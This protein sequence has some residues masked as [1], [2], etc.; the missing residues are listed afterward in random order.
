MQYL[1]L[2]IEANRLFAVSKRPL[3]KGSAFNLD[4]HT[5]VIVDD[6]FVL[7][8][9]LLDETGNPIVDDQGKIVIEEK[10]ASEIL[11]EIS[12][13]HQRISEYPSI[14]DQ[15]DLMYHEGYDAWKALIQSI[16]EKY[17]KPE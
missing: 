1:Y 3:V 10:T 16:K 8:K 7:T 4:H 2:D 9:T 12:Y 6:N 14:E 11:S 5:E 15:L 13:V 17:P